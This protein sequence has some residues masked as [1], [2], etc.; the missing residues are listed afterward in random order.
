[1]I[2]PW[3]A[4]R[5]RCLLFCARVALEA[6]ARDRSASSLD[7]LIYGHALIYD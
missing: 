2:R 4:R 7:A 5:E 3:G 1:V 6:P